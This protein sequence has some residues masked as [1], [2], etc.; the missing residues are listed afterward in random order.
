MTSRPAIDRRRLLGWG[1]AALVGSLLPALPSLSPE[2]EAAGSP[3]FREYPFTLGVASGDPLPD[4][5]VIWTRLAP[6]PTV[7]DGGLPPE[8]FGVRWEVSED[9][10]F[11]RVVRRGAVAALPESAHSVHVDVTGLRPDRVYYYRFRAGTAISPTG[12]T[13]TAPAVGTHLERLAFAFVSC[14]NFTAGYYTAYQDLARRDLDFVLHLGDYIYE[15]DGAGPGAA[16]RLTRSIE[17]KSLDDYRVRHADYKRDAGLQAAHA[18]FPFILTW[19]DHEFDNGYSSDDTDP[20]STPEEFFAR[21]TA[22]YQAYYEHLPLRPANRPVGPAAQLYR[23]LSFG[24]LLQLHVLDTRQYRSDQPQCSTDD[25]PEARDPARTMLGEQQEAWLFDGLGASTA[26]WDV[27]GN[28]VPVRRYGTRQLGGDQ[29]D[30]Y[31]AARSRL[32]QFLAQRGPTNPIVVTGDLHSNQVSD[33]PASFDEPGAPIV[34]TEF[35]GT[36]ITSGGDETRRTVYDGFGN[37]WERFRNFGQR[38]YV[39]VDLTHDTFLAD[40]RGVQTVRQQISPAYTVE[41]FAL[42]AGQRG[43]QIA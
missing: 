39:A 9:E 8:S 41:K 3:F 18:A 13:R 20:D 35:M 15:G 29:W 25:C 31:D 38:G 12:R 14:Q 19:D 5:V 4:A 6:D 34:A 1:G 11:S 32:L 2:A 28:Q 40:Y 23:R 16:R 42:Q 21:R 7:P 24:D 17:A 30:G 22:A 26:V 43:A 37:S 27:L 10:R 33:L 36:S